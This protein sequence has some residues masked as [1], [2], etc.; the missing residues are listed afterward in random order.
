MTAD[1]AVALVLHQIAKDQH[2]RVK[3]SPYVARKFKYNKE[4]EEAWGARS[5]RS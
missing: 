1:N 3:H 4:L 5:K 2:L